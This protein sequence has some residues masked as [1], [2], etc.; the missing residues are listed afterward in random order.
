MD[1]GLTF[2]DILLVPQYSEVTSRKRCNISVDFLGER[3]RSPFI[4]ANMD[5]ITSVEM[6]TLTMKRFG[7][8][9]MHRFMPLNEQVAFVRDAIET[10]YDEDESTLPRFTPLTIGV[11]ESVEDLAS[12]LSKPIWENQVSGFSRRINLVLVDV[13]HAHSVNVERRVK[14][15]KENFPDIKVIV[16]NIAT[17]HAFLSVVDW[18]A[19]AVKVGIG[20]GSICSTRLTTGC[21]MPQITAI[22]EINSARIDAGY[23]YDTFPIIADGGM[24]H[25][26]DAAKALAAGA[27][28]VMSGY[29]FAGCPETP[30]DQIDKCK[31]Y[32]GM[33]SKEA[34][35]DWEP[36]K[37]KDH[38]PE[39]VSRW[40]NVKP[41]AEIIFIEAEQALRSTM[42]YCGVTT[43][44]NLY[45]DSKVLR[46]TGRSAVEGRTI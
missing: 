29:F 28:M 33:A 5:T 41:S 10:V 30:G 1:V 26:G 39:G 12:I 27:N 44:E 36:L 42:S 25:Y 35:E 45:R 18:G 19:D 37:L 40:V 32:R 7:L 8:G 43:I 6:L 14:W 38:T 2:D 20:N 22:K 11:T 16:G 34:R 3:L 31:A 17:R 23:S 46:Q 9:F 13:A 15:L 4:P 24:R 21:G